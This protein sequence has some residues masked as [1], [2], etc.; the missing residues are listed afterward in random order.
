VE[1]VR[2]EGEDRSEVG[3]A[4]LLLLRGDRIDGLLKERLL[5]RQKERKHP[6]KKRRK[7]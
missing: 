2:E 5:V 1:V 4:R 6:R 3:E 7:N